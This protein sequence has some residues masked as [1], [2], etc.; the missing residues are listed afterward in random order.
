LKAGFNKA[1]CVH[2][3]D[4]ETD[5]D[6][7]Q[8]VQDFLDPVPEHRQGLYLRLRKPGDGEVA[9]HEQGYRIYFSFKKAMPYR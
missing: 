5:H 6:E 3:G 1:D 9:E 4:R 7:Q 2:N 8:G